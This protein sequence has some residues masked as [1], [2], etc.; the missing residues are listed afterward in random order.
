MLQGATLTEMIIASYIS[1]A[2]MA[3]FVAIIGALVV[4]ALDNTRHA[5]G[6]IATQH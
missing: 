4:A 6:R 5:P 1:F 2:W 3:L